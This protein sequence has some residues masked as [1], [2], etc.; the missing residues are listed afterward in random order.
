MVNFSTNKWFLKLFSCFHYPNE[1]CAPI[2]KVPMPSWSQGPSHGLLGCLPTKSMPLHP[3]NPP[4]V[5][6]DSTG[7]VPGICEQ[8]WTWLLI[9]CRDREKS[10]IGQSLLGRRRRFLY[11]EHDTICETWRS[12]GGGEAFFPGSFP[13]I[14]TFPCHFVLFCLLHH[15]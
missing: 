12:N 8:F 3:S 6:P 15:N 7:K 1:Q 4:N 9:Y 10:S 11:V 5:F 14:S 2:S 13:F